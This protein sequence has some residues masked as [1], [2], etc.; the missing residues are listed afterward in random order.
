MLD[1]N[2]GRFHFSARGK[3]GDHIHKQ[4]AVVAVLSRLYV[5]VASVV[6]IRVGLHKSGAG[7]W[8]ELE[9]GKQRMFTEWQPPTGKEERMG[10]KILAEKPKNDGTA[11]QELD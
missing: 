11:H 5:G 9:E 1:A 2:L 3:R 10:K 8:C 4:L 7:P 6:D